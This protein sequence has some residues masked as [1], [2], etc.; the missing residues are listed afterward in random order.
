VTVSGSNPYV[1]DFSVTPKGA[2]LVAGATWS[3]N[4]EAKTLAPNATGGAYRFQAE[5][6]INYPDIGLQCVDDPAVPCD[7][8]TPAILVLR[9]ATAPDIKETR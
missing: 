8:R 6:W 3:F 5:A 9:G 2:G 1:L 4:L 7:R